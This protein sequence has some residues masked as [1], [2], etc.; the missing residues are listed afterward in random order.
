MAG[1]AILK[2]NIKVTGIGNDVEMDNTATLTVPVEVQ[3]G[4]TIVETA[5]TT[6]IQLFDMVDHIALNKIYGV[7]LKAEVGTIYITVDTTGTGTITSTTA[8][9]VLN[10]GESTYIPVNPDGNLGMVID[11]AAVTDAFSWLILGKT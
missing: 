1:A 5:T 7:Y 10:V 4:Y 11:A 9:L 3:S 2:T 6:A 8:D